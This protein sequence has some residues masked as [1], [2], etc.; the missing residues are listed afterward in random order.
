MKTEK[1]PWYIYIFNRVGGIWATCIGEE[2]TW[3]RSNEREV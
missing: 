1:L 3:K 2:E